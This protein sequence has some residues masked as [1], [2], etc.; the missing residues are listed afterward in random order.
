MKFITWTARARKWISACNF[1]MD[2]FTNS[3]HMER[4]EHIIVHGSMCSIH[5]SSSSSIASPTICAIIL[6]LVSAVFLAK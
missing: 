6:V 3:D 4:L 1:A 5:N 2:H